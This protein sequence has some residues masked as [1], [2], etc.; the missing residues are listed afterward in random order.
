LDSRLVVHDRPL[1][2]SKH[3]LDIFKTEISFTKSDEEEEEEEERSNL[4]T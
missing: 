3:H 2:F 4:E 1:K